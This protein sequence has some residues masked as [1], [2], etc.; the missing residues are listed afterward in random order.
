MKRLI[1]NYRGAQIFEEK[2]I[3]QRE[4]RELKKKLVATATVA[5]H[6]NLRTNFIEDGDTMDEAMEKM[7]NSIDR[8]LQMNLLLQFEHK[9]NQK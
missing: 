6:K 8:Y 4:G 7:H 3:D 1:E 2:N 9:V 5:G